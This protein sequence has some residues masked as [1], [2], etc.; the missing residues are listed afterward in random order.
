MMS[1]WVLVYM[2]CAGR[3][4]AQYAI[5]YETRGECVRH[6]PKQEGMVLKEKYVCIPTSKD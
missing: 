6:I 2:I 3:C 1:S 5:P 4:E